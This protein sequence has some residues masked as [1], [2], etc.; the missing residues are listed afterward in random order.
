MYEANQVR[1]H[2]DA[3]GTT[4]T[5]SIGEMPTDPRCPVGVHVREGFEDKGFAGAR[6]ELDQATRK[7]KRDGYAIKFSEE[8]LAVTDL[9]IRQSV[10]PPKIT[11]K[12]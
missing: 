5:T 1:S 11:R 4:H 12:H 2:T 8:P 7:G 3:S 9:S 6:E 10:E